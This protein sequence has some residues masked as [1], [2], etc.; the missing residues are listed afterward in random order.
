M[1]SIGPDL[2]F[3][4]TS[5]ILALTLLVGIFQLFI[6]GIKGIYLIYR[7]FFCVIKNTNPENNE[8]IP[9]IIEE[10]LLLKLFLPYLQADG[11]SSKS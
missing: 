2:S 9:S 5:T 1:G 4:L 11:L 3:S 10:R 6:H 8:A 7:H